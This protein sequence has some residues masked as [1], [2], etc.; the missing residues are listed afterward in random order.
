MPRKKI[1]I[2]QEM[3]LSSHKKLNKNFLYSILRKLPWGK[4]EA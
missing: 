2:F 3:E 4:L 1:L